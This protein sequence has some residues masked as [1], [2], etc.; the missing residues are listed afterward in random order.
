MFKKVVYIGDTNLERN[1]YFAKYVD[2]QGM[3]REEFYRTHFDFDFIK[4]E[5]NLI[6]LEVYVKFKTSSYLFDE[7]LIF[8]NT[9]YLK[10]NIC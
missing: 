9:S 8:I 3:A 7:I 2:W 10:K 4:E 5:I 6:T 1:V